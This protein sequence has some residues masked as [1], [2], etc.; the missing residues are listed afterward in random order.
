MRGAIIS[1]PNVQPEFISSDPARRS[2][3]RLR[4]AALALALVVAA[5]GCLSL[6]GSG[7]VGHDPATGRA[8]SVAAT[9]NRQS[10]SISSEK[11]QTSAVVYIKSVTGRKFGLLAHCL[12]RRDGVESRVVLDPAKDWWENPPI[13]YREAALE[14]PDAMGDAECEAIKG[15]GAGSNV[16][17]SATLTC[18]ASVA[19]KSRPR[20]DCMKGT[21]T[22][23]LN[24]RSRF[25]DDGWTD[26][27]NEKG[28]TV[29]FAFDTTDRTRRLRETGTDRRSITIS[30]E[31]YRRDRQK[32]DRKSDWPAAPE[33]G[34]IQSV[35]TSEDA[36]LEITGYAYDDPPASPKR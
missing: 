12:G 3:L 35:F 30:L 23:K 31:C 21:I 8:S 6:V 28:K 34:D 26:L 11:T 15:I 17:V 7:V 20:S 13:L 29:V 33:R 14:N 22:A 19:L 32:W 18:H 36:V 1:H 4:T 16:E 27:V 2:F 10:E 24:A 5:A 9:S 25:Y